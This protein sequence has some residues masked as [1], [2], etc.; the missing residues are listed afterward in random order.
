MSAE[1]CSQERTYGWSAYL[2]PRLGQ[3]DLLRLA[4]CNDVIIG[5]LFSLASG[6]STLSSPLVPI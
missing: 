4:D 2:L 6:S 5:S 3:K 1:P